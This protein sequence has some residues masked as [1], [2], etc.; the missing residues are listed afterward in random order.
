MSTIKFIFFFLT[1]Y[2]AFEGNREFNPGSNLLVEIMASLGDTCML[3]AWIFWTRWQSTVNVYKVVLNTVTTSRCH[4]GTSDPKL[5]S[6]LLFSHFFLKKVL[7]QNFIYMQNCIKPKEQPPKRIKTNSSHL[8]NFYFILKTYI[9]Q[10][11]GMGAHWASLNVRI[12]VMVN[13]TSFQ[14]SAI[15]NKAERVCIFH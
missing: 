12:F 13:E 4:T 5:C 9:L 3:A 14:F 1:D 2:W 6:L 15:E 10:S 7:D 11:S 8:L